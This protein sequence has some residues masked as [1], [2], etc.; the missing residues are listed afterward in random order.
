MILFGLDR[1]YEQIVVLLPGTVVEATNVLW[2]RDGAVW[3]VGRGQRAV[4]LRTERDDPARTR[5]LDELEDVVHVTRVRQ[6]VGA[7]DVCAQ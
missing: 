6:R 4:R 7:G 5:L 3:D 2:V 1:V